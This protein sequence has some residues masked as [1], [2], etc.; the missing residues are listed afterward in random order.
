MTGNRTSGRL[1]LI[2]QNAIQIGG[3]YRIPLTFSQ[4]G[5][6]TPIDLSG[7]LARPNGAIAQ[8]RASASSAIA[9]DIQVEFVSDG[10]DGAIVLVFPPT[11]TS[12]LKPGT[13]AWD[14]RL[15]FDDDDVWFALKGQ[16]AAEATA[17]RVEVMP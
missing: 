4:K 3:S 17:T 11:M 15:E 2:G 10:S 9:H 8:M 13:Y 1:D 5:T 6:G 14:L 16:I 12:A 7:A